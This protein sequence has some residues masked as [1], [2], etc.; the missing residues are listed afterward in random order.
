MTPNEIIH[1]SERIRKYNLHYD[2]VRGVKSKAPSVR[3][4]SS[5][6]IFLIKF[7]KILQAVKFFR[8]L[9]SDI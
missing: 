6:K 9:G 2:E 5:V 4:P 1:A 3:I 8:Q 7:L